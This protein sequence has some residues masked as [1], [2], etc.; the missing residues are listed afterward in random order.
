[1]RNISGHEA[2]KAVFNDTAF[3]V[4]ASMFKRARPI[5]LGGIIAAPSVTL[6][7]AARVNH[8]AGALT[9]RPPR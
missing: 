7:R 8:K 9:E 5:R 1:M 6:G 3:R 4:C 2:Y